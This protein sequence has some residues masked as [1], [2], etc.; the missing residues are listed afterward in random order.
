MVILIVCFFKLNYLFLLIQHTEYQTK[1][2]G[3]SGKGGRSTIW[4]ITRFTKKA[5]GF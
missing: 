3:L 2:E 5:Y 1:I 4:K